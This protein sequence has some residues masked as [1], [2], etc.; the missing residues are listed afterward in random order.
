MI[1]EPVTRDRIFRAAIGATNLITRDDKTL[2][3]VCQ[4]LP[5]TSSLP[6]SNRVMPDRRRLTHFRVED[7]THR[8]FIDAFFKLR[9]DLHQQHRIATASRFECGLFGV[10]G[11]NE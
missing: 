2:P 3:A 7:V 11:R 10:H 5:M 1:P 9:A 6:R 8:D 4:P